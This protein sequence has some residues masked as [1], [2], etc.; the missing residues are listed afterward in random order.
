MANLPT[1]NNNPGDLKG[2]NGFQT[3]SSPQ[4]GHAALLNDIT[5]KMTGT[6]STGVGPNS[7]IVEFAKV[8][9][10]AS[11]K[12]N[13]AQYAANIANHLG[14]SPDTPIG[15][16]KD[17]IGEFADA[18][19]GNEGYQASNGYNPKPFSQPSNGANPFLVDTSGATPD[20]APKDG[21]VKSL[22]KDAAGIVLRPA[23]NLLNAGAVLDGAPQNDDNAALRLP[24]AVGNYLGNFKPIGTEGTFGQKVKD[25]AGQAAKTASYAVGGEGAADVAGAGLKGLIKEGIITGAKQGAVAGTLGGGGQAATENKSLEQIGIGSVLGGVGGSLLGGTIGGVLPVPKAA[26]N[27][28]D[29]VKI[30]EK[31]E[32]SAVNALAPKLTG[33]AETN[34]YREVVTKGRNLTPSGLFKGANLAPSEQ[35]NMLAKRLSDIPFTENEGKNLNLLRSDLVKTESKLDAALKGDNEIIYNLDKP[36]LIEKLN[37][38]KDE[39]PGDFIGESGK[40]YDNVIAFGKKMIGDAEDTIQGG[41]KARTAFDNE[42]KRKFPTAYKNGVL[43]RA[44]PAGHA[45][46]EVRDL[47]NDHI[48]DVAPN[49]SEIQKLIGRESDIFRATDIIANKAK[50]ATGGSVQKFVQDRP[51]IKGAINMIKGTGLLG[52]IG[53]LI[54]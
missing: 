23:A 22:V 10:P 30:A 51:V 41:R 42:T 49:G 36:T 8:Y 2:S 54:H 44:T 45:I 19:S 20:Q 7:S 11:D 26:L 13:P 16:L 37:G 15:T 39:K 21:F 33:N 48:Y 14:V 29:P 12:N 9:A 3:Y 32:G 27:R 38:V 17:R 24:G 50:R 28:F 5:A 6:S 35:T 47:I 40:I 31:A 34:A 25:V 4:D 53:N 18:I 1:R 43:N 52:G 46:G